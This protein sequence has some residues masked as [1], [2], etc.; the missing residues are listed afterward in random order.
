VDNKFF[1]KNEEIVR[2]KQ[3]EWAPETGAETSASLASP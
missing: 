2:A 1:T 3:L